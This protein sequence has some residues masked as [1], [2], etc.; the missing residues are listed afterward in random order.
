MVACRVPRSLMYFSLPLLVIAA[1]LGAPGRRRS[2]TALRLRSGPKPS[3]RRILPDR[4][5]T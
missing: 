2:L 3:R 1:L 5:Q 4:Y